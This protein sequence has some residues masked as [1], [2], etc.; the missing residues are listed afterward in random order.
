LAASFLWFAVN[1]ERNE[2]LVIDF[3]FPP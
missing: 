1:A 2:G 3:Y